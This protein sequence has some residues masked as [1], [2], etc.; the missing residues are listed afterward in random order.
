MPT[1]VVFFA[2]DVAD[3][4][5]DENDIVLRKDLTAGGDKTTKPITDSK[6]VE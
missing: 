3:D 2:C 4:D 1:G 5:D 6:S